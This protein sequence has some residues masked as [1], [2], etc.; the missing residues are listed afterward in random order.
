MQYCLIL[1]LRNWPIL[2]FSIKSI[3]LPELVPIRSALFLFQTN[4]VNWQCKA[5]AHFY[6]GKRVHPVK[7]Y[8]LFNLLVK[9]CFDSK[10]TYV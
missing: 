1:K 8:S 9:K 7:E 4:F 6:N 2:S 3:P 5:F 10:I